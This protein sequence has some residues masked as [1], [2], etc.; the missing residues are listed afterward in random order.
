MWPIKTVLHP[1]DFSDCSQ[2]AFRVASSLARDHGARLIV[3]HVTSLPDLAYRGYGLPGSPL[4]AE[5]YLTKVREDL[6]RLN[7]PDPQ[8]S[9]ERRLAE[10][11]PAAEILRT[12]AETGASLIVMGTHGMS[13]PRHLLMGSVA[14]QIVRKAPC[15]VVTVTAATAETVSR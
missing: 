8:V 4:R 1:T 7:P 11:D 10:G 9:C 6:E 13:G 3:L 15:P 2:N 12:A 5:E 14:K